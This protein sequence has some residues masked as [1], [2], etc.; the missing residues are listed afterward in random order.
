METRS[1]G[2]AFAPNQKLGGGRLG[3]R[4]GHARSVTRETILT[5]DISEGDV[6]TEKEAAA[7]L[8]ITPGALRSRRFR[9]S[10]S[11]PPFVQHGRGRAVMYVKSWFKPWLFDGYIDPR[12]ESDP[13]PSSNA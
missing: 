10:P 9:K 8:G 1:K 3:R 4:G 6:I 2:V 11:C 7:L 12:D 13:P 5:M